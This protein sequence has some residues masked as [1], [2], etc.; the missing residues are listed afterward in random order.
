MKDIYDPETD[1]FEIWDDLESNY[2]NIQPNPLNARFQ[3]FPPLPLH[4]EAE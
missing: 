2:L 3:N 4:T 1:K